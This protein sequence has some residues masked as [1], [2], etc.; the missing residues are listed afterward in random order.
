[1]YIEDIRNIISEEEFDFYG[2]RVDSCNIYNVSDICEN[3]HQWWQDDPE[4][5]SQY[6]EQN[7]L[8]D[9]GELNGTCCIRV[10]E[11]NIEDIINAAEKGYFG[12]HITLVAGYDAEG[13]N[14]RDEIIIS[15]AK[16]LY[17]IK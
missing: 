5:G 12:D 1:M 10:R 16:V 9:G 6:N 3:S 8:W 7:H 14:D 13:G 17:V 2:I 4:D 11:D 15:N